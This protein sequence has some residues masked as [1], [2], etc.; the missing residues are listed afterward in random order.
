MNLALEVSHKYP[1]G[2]ATQAILYL[3]RSTVKQNKTNLAGKSKLE[4]HKHGFDCV[5]ICLT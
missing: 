3:Y 2:G 1:R 4:H 5:L